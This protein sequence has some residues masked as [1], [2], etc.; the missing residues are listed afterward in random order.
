[1]LSLE[2]VLQIVNGAQMMS[3]M[4]EYLR[5]NQVIVEEEDRLKMTF[6]TKWGTFAYRRMPFG[7]INAGATFQRAMDYAFKDLKDKCIIIYMDDI[8][9]FSKNREDHILD[10]RKVFTRCRKFRVS[11]NLKKCMF[12]VTEGKILGNVI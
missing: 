8:T 7:L 12:G 11:L 3:F 4:D 5:Y 10:L 9:E 1:M 6:T 2:E